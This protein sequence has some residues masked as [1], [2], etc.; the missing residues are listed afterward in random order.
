MQDQPRIL[1]TYHRI[2]RLPVLGVRT[3]FA[4]DEAAVIEAIRARGFRIVVDYAYSSAS[5][6]L[7]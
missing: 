3:A 5:L 1:T 6:V 7:P 4:A 2:E